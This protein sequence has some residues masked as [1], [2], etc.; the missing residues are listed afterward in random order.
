MMFIR[1]LSFALG[2][3]AVVFTLN[4][5]Y[6]TI[7]L[8]WNINHIWSI[9][10]FWPHYLI[11][12]FSNPEIVLPLRPPQ[13]VYLVT[14]V[15]APVLSVILAKLLD[16]SRLDWSVLQSYFPIYAHYSSAIETGTFKLKS[17]RWFHRRIPC[18]SHWKILWQVQES[19]A[20]EFS[21]R[22]D[23]SILWSI[24]EL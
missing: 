20:I 17:L 10:S 24:L 3:G 5:I 12:M 16:R 4:Y 21:C 11:F 18:S 2:L 23:L 1:F 8:T 15:G 9:V 14:Q 7:T 19:S 22:A 6:I 13:Y